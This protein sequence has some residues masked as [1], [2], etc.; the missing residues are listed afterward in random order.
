MIALYFI[1]FRRK[2]AVA[3]FGRISLICSPLVLVSQAKTIL[4]VLLREYNIEIVGELPPPDFDAM[5][6]G[7]KGKCTVRYTKRTSC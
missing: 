6:L 4:S 7:P 2:I 3:D 5:L 1:V